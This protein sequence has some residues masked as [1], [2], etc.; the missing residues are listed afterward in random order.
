MPKKKPL[1]IYDLAHFQGLGFEALNTVTLGDRSCVVFSRISPTTKS[2]WEYQ[3]S[4]LDDEGFRRHLNPD[5]SIDSAPGILVFIDL[6][7]KH[8]ILKKRP[9]Y[10]IDWAIC[11][12]DSNDYPSNFPSAVLRNRALAEVCISGL[13]DL[14]DD[15]FSI[16]EILPDGRQQNDRYVSLLSIAGAFA[17]NGDWCPEVQLRL[18]AWSAH[19]PGMKMAI[20]AGADPDK[21][22]GPEGLNPLHVSAR[23]GRGE[24]LRAL[25]EN[26]ADPSAMDERGNTALHWAALRGH[27]DLCAFLLNKVDL[28][29]KNSKGETALALAAADPG[30]NGAELVLRAATARLAAHAAVKDVGALNL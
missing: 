26:G 21:P 16:F 4:V 30:N 18:S 17:M 12:N 28:E 27:K 15:T 10:G 24:A 6:M 22:I 7:L 11:I 14:I 20:Q 23:E 13:T 1:P 5:E 19:T 2:K 29:A 25:L 9:P 3:L 8:G